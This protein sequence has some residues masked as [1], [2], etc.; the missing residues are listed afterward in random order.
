ML[1]WRDWPAC[2]TRVGGKDRNDLTAA[3]RMIKG[4]RASW[5]SEVNSRL[6]I[7]NKNVNEHILLCNWRQLLYVPEIP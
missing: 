6:Q 4:E 5:Q 7:G 3:F 1:F 2:L